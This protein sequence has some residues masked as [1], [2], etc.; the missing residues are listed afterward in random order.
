MRCIQHMVMQRH[1]HRKQVPKPQVSNL[2]APFDRVND[3]PFRRVGE[4]L[5]QRARL[6]DQLGTRRCPAVDLGGK[7]RLTPLE[8]DVMQWFVELATRGIRGFSCVQDL[9][10]K[11]VETFFSEQGNGRKCGSHSYEWGHGV[12]S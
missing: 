6:P 7:R 5:F 12:W 8:A 4:F 1:A 11:G 2:L 9:G 10:L 3:V